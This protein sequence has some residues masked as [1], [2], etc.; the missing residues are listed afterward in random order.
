M[1][2]Y[3]LQ[4]KHSEHACREQPRHHMWGGAL[5]G[6][7]WRP[8]GLLLASGPSVPAGVSAVRKVS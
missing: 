7:G 6:K 1:Q 5:A 2:R 4:T 8:L 3:L